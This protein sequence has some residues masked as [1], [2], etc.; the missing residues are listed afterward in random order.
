MCEE[1]SKLTREVREEREQQRNNRLE[2][3]LMG[4]ACVTE[5]ASGFEIE[6]LLRMQKYA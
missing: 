2:V 4:C 6:W 3:D 5:T 1:S